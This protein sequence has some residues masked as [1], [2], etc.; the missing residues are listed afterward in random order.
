M[1]RQHPA[2]TCDDRVRWSDESGRSRDPNFLKFREAV[3]A[4]AFRKIRHKR[5]SSQIA[6]GRQRMLPLVQVAKNRPRASGGQISRSGG[7]SKGGERT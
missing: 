4:K 6:S 7:H 3:L 1:T 5:K 2:P